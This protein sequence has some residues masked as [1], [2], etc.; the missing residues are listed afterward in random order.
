LEQANRLSKG[1]DNDREG[2]VV[3]QARILTLHS[4]PLEA[5]ISLV[6]ST[7][8]GAS[9]S[10]HIDASTGIHIHIYVYIYINIYIYIYICTCIYIC[11]YIGHL[12]NATEDDL[13]AQEKGSLVGVM[14]LGKEQAHKGNSQ[15]LLVMWKFPSIFTI[16]I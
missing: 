6:V 12:L 10:W 16:Y 13:S 15:Y 5:H 1:N 7:K 11:I 14:A 9:Y 4:S 3:V 8:S 2:D